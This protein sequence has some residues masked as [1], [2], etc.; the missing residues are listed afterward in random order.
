MLESVLRNLR[1]WGQNEEGWVTPFSLIFSIALIGFGGVAYEY[2]EIV[3]QKK[4][5]Q[6]ATDAVALAATT[7]LPNR[8]AAVEMGL[9]VA[10]K[11]FPSENTPVTITAEDFV[12]GLWD[13][14]T[15]SF[16]VS[17]EPAT[18]V[19]VKAIRSNERQNIAYT[20]FRAF[21]GAGAYE[22]RTQ[23]VA[24]VKG[25]PFNACSRGGFISASYL[26]TGSHNS[27]GKGFCTYGELGMEI[28]NN[29]YYESAAT[30]Q[31]GHGAT[32]YYG[33]NNDC[34]GS[35]ICNLETPSDPSLNKDIT[36]PY[37]EDYLENEIKGGNVSVF[38]EGDMYTVRYVTKLPKRK[39]VIPYSIYIVSGDA[40]FSSNGNYENLIVLADGGSIKAGANTTFYNVVLLADNDIQF[41]SNTQFGNGNHCEEGRYQTYMFA[42]GNI[43][44]GSNNAMNAMQMAAKGTLT[45]GTNIT[46]IGDIHGETWGDVTFN[47]EN[48]LNSCAT[49]L[50]SDFG[51][52]PDIQAEDRFGGNRGLV[53]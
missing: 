22:L 28:G 40:E 52:A 14:D 1:K 33:G 38:R 8:T 41:G 49:A 53:M 47:S 12:F 51:W 31:G 16:T 20:A 2:A 7:A 21:T 3:R 32:F 17:S 43:R 36:L 26:Y 35:A 15:K 45:F 48:T 5:F 42:E 39:K 50:V 34:G 27:F 11:Y 13:D 19:Q 30:L 46:S 10:A 6:T 37:S 9:K 44:L 4:Q 18:A 29:N 23:S 25:T 24:R